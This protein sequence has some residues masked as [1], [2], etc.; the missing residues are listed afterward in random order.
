[1]SIRRVLVVVGA[2]VAVLAVFVAGVIVG[3]HPE[4]TGL[5]RL[6]DPLRSVVLGDSGEDLPSQVLDA[7][8]R[9]YYEPVD[10]E[11]LQRASADAVVE[12]LGDPYTD[13]LDP[14]ELEALRARNDGAYFGVGLQV[15][16]RGAAVV[17]TKVFPDSPASR[18]DVRVGDRISSIDGKSAAGKTLEEV[19]GTIRGPEGTPVRVGVVTGD[20]PE[21]ILDLERARIRVSAVTSRV[22]TVDGEKVGYVALAQFTRGASD[23]LREAVEDLRGTGV[24]ALV[25]DLRGDPGGLVTEAVGVSG[26]FLPDD[27]E[28]VVTEGLHS[29]RQELRTDGD[30]ATGDLPLVVLVNRGSASASEIVAGA[31]RDADRAT[32]VGERTFGKALVQSTIP[33]RDGGALKLTTARYLTPSGF[34][35]AER[36]L[37]PDVRVVDDPATPRDEALRRGLALAAAAG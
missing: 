13:Y 5:T 20:A 9:D 25:L 36:G 29:P 27:T 18:T 1:M 34:D 10:V 35:L 12:A 8:R 3:G 28:V 30:P 23:A 7:L 26:V 21:R 14:D 22:E 37:P 33:L 11:K 24:T 17:V 15:A 19:V 32:L 16:Q 31:L 6:D 4:D 2:V